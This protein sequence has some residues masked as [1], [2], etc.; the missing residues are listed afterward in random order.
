MAA[1][2][3]DRRPSAATIDILRTLVAFPTVSRDSNLD[4]IHWVRDYLAGHGIESVLSQGSDPGKANLF[5][6]I[7][8]RNG[9]KGEGG[10][11]L[12]GHSDVVPVEGQNWSSDPFVLEERDG[13]LFGRGTCDMKGF[14]AACLAK[15]PALAAAPLAEPVHLAISFD[16]EIGC[17]GVGHMLHDLVDRGVKPRGCVVGEPTSMDAVIGHKTGSAYGC[18]VTGLEMHSSLAPMGVNAIF[19]AARVIGWIE[20]KAAQLRAEEQR[21]DGYSVPFST[22]SVGVIEGG[23][24]SNIVPALCR[25]RFDIRTLPWTDP[26]A[27][28]A[29]LEAWIARDLLPEMRAIAPD[30]D[31]RIGMNGRVPGFAIDADAPLTRYVQ[32]L[33]GSNAPPSFVAFG[34]EAGLF[35]AKGVPSV[36]CG[37]GSIEQ[38]HKPDEYVSLEQL[39][40]CED[41]LDRLATTP[42]AQAEALSIISG[43]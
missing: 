31:I 20:A 40:R 35:Q 28:I 23:F 36:L 25:F 27:I 42:F 12:S 5:A 8:G 1:R 41:F 2:S 26:D 17:K 43:I 14:I 19:Y 33:A 22:L 4:L 10:I 30:A 21:H 32:R 7:P 38:A 15:V 11:V 9:G 29:E 24:A 37:P 18:A 39:A 3:A 6:T 16:E 34:S 13:K